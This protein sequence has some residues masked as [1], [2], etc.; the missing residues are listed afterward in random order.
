MSTLNVVEG[1]IRTIA[2]V[3]QAIK[4]DRASVAGIVSFHQSVIEKRNRDL[5][6]VTVVE[7]RAIDIANKLD[8]S[9]IH[10]V[11]HN[12]DAESLHKL[13]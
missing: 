12:V 6:A 11:C 8:V 9:S 2:G 5:N 3:Q 13:L 10:S 1:E 7:E 4:D